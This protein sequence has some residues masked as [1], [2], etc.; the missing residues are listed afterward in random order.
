MG[1]TIP[2]HL[3]ANIRRGMH[4]LGFPCPYTGNEYDIELPFS[5]F[6]LDYRRMKRTQGD[7]RV[8]KQVVTYGTCSECGRTVTYMHHPKNP[9]K[10]YS[11]L[12]GVGPREK[13]ITLLGYENDKVEQGA[14]YVIAMNG[15]LLKKIGNK[16]PYPSDYNDRICYSSDLTKLFTYGDDKILRIWDVTSEELLGEHELGVERP[17]IFPIPG[18]SQLLVG[19]LLITYDESGKITDTQDMDELITGEKRDPYYKGTFTEVLEDGERLVTSE[20]VIY[21]FQ[22]REVVPPLARVSFRFLTYR[23][24]AAATAKR[25]VNPT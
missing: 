9:S 7:T 17:N 8:R 5:L 18:K 22:G 15:A 16:H 19:Y 6:N 20:G 23:S 25:I 10:N 11:M 12:F 2:G 1:A 24:V 14:I 3:E 4:G 13:V 21:N